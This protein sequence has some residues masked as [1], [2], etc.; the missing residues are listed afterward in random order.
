MKRKESKLSVILIVLSFIFASCEKEITTSNLTLDK[1]Q[2]AKVKAYFYA[3]L[4]KT[5]QG[6]ELAPN[7]TKVFISIPN[8]SLCNTFGVS[9]NWID[10]ATIN[11]GIIEVSV[12]TVSTGVTVTLKAAEFSYDQVQSFGSVSNTIPKIFSVTG[13]QTISVSPGESKTRE[14]TYDS[15]N[16]L[17]NFAEKV[18]CAFILKADMD[19]TIAGNENV[20]QNT[21]VNLYTSTWAGTATVDAVGKISA[22]IPK[23][24]PVSINF[25]A[26]KTLI[27]PPSKKYL[28]T[29]IIPAQSVN[30]SYVG[31]ITLSGVQNEN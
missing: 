25:E 10:S 22:T 19:E 31:T 11:N 18:N 12:P 13:A 3:E 24:E 4:D 28:Y 1:S 2:K 16:Q 30:R 15:Q 20:P 8:S 26:T 6:L 5:K 23:D 21:T 7:G 17:D 14:I 9:G 29:G 27:V